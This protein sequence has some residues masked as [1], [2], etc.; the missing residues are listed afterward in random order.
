MTD[1]VAWVLRIVTG[2][3]RVLWVQSF[4]FINEENRNL[5]GWRCAVVVN[6]VFIRLSTEN[7]RK[8]RICS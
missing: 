6:V 7:V 4:S 5:M 2:G 8:P 1:V 3:H